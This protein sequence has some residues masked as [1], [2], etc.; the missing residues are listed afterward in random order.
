MSVWVPARICQDE[1][2]HEHGENAFFELQPQ[3]ALSNTKHEKDKEDGKLE[4]D[5]WA[6][7]I[8]QSATITATLTGSRRHLMLRDSRVCRLQHHTLLKM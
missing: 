3:S 8:Q 2:E 1:H 4:T 5:D 6:Q 7:L